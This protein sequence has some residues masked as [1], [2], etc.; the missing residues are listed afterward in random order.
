MSRKCPSAQILEAGI[1]CQRVSTTEVYL[2]MLSV[3]LAYASH[4]K[5]EFSTDASHHQTTRPREL[6]RYF[7]NGRPRFQLSQAQ[8]VLKQI[9]ALILTIL[10][11]Q[12][13]SLSIQLLD[14]CFQG[15]R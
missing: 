6:H 11:Y 15:I 10:R 8:L 2:I 9:Q 4:Q 5:Q 14:K 12:M 7:T 1:C 3:Y 13:K